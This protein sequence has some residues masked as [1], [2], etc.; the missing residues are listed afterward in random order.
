VSDENVVSSQV[1]MQVSWRDL[2]QVPVQSANQF[3][4]QVQGI[5]NAPPDDILLTAGYVAPPFA[6][7]PDT[8][9]VDVR[10]IARVSMSRTRAEELVRTLQLSIDQYDRAQEVPRNDT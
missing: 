5:G 7:T 6:L 3:L 9:S 2:D 1:T 8:T 10:P 4:V